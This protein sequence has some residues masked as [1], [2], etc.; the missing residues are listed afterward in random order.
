MK[1]QEYENTK[2]INVNEEL[3]NNEYNQIARD[4]AL[5]VRKEHRLTV[6]KNATKTTIRISWKTLAYVAFLMIANILI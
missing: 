5:T 6:L 4:L 1:I 3:N 2:V